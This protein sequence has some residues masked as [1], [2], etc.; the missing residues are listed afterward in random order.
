MRIQSILKLSLLITPALVGAVCLCA[1]AMAAPDATKSSAIGQRAAAAIQQRDAEAEIRQHLPIMVYQRHSETAIANN[2]HNL[3]VIDNVVGKALEILCLALGV[4]IVVSGV[5]E[6]K[7]KKDEMVSIAIGTG[8]VLFGLFCPP[9]VHAVC[10][11]AAQH[12]FH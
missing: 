6:Q 12:L 10:E 1:P 5:I 11:F 4:A 2:R 3:N 9:A 8:L 7:G